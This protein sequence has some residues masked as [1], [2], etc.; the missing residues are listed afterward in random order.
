M[1]DIDYIMELI[2]WNQSAEDQERGIQMAEN[3]QS[4]NVFLQPCNK[5]YNK[6]VWENC[7]RVLAKRTDEELSYYFEELM[8][9][10]QDMN[11]PGAFCILER[12]KHMSDIPGFWHSYE[13]C[14]ECARA[15]E[16]GT[17]ISNLEM[18]KEEIQSVSEAGYEN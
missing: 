2:D 1:I 8:G 18:L 16:D 3:I 12:L 17:W 15:L 13:I 9:W 4:I 11:W 14:M 5:K 7:A 10:L 6:N